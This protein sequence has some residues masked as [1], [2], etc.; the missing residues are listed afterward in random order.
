MPPK[1]SSG[2]EKDL[3]DE[4][5]VLQAVIL[6]DSFNKRFKPLTVGKPRC[7]LPVCNATLLDWTFESLALAGVQE[8]FVICRSYPELVKAAIRDSK[9]SKPM[10]GLKIV[11]IITSKETF[12]P[13]DAMRDIYTRGI[14][15]SDFVLVMG[16]LVSNVKIDEVVRVHK[17][18]RRTNK[19]AIMTMVVKESGSV[20]R[21]RSQG[22]SAVFVLDAETSECLHYESVIGYPAKKAVQIPREIFKDHP[23]L[24]VRYDLI[25]CCI[26]VCSVE[27]PSLFQDNFDYG[28]I[29]R[30]F[31]HGV[32]TSDLLMKSIHCYVLNEGYAARVADTRS[33]DAVS[34]DILSRWTFPLVPDDNHPGGHSYEHLRGNKYIAKGN[35]V[36]L[37]RTCKIGPNTLIGAGSTIS[38][39][40][41]IHASVIGRNCTISPNVVLKNVYVFDGTVIGE[42]SV[43]EETIIGENV[44]IGGGSRID[45]G[46]LIADGVVLGKNARLGPFDRVSKR[47]EVEKKKSINGTEESDGEEDEEEEDSELEDVEAHQDGVSV[48]IG[49]GSNA[50]V[51][52]Q[53]PREDDEDIDEVE[54]YS[55]QRLM[56]L[57]DTCSDLELEPEDDS[58]ANDSDSDDSDAE[59]TTSMGSNAYS[60]ASST[61]SYTNNPAVGIHNLQAA[62]AVTEFQYEVGQ[63]LERAFAEG[64]S[65]DNAAV[66]LKTLRMASNVELRKVRE[67]VVK[68]IVEKIRIVEEGG[69]EQR[70][71]IA[72][73][74]KRWGALIDKIGGVDAVETVEVLQYHCAQSSRLPLFGQI[75]AALYQED[76]VEEDDIR[77]WHRTAAAKGE[78]LK[79]GTTLLEHVQRCWT[80]GSKMIEQFDEQESS[81]EEESEEE[82]K[83]KTAQPTVKAKEESSEEEE[84]DDDDEESEE[85]ESEE[86][87]VPKAADVKP[88]P[89]ASKPAAPGPSVP[90]QVKKLAESSEEE[91][92]EDRDEEEE[93]E[94]ESDED[95][96]PTPPT[97]ANKSST[98]APSSSQPPAPPPQPAAPAP[99]IQPKKA[100]ETSE[101]EEDDDDEEEESGEEESDEEPAPA[102]KATAPAPAPATSAPVQAP[103]P[104][105][106]VAPASEEEESEEDDEDDEE[107]DSGEEE[108]E[109]EPVVAPAP[110][111]PATRVA[112]PPAAQQP[113]PP[114]PAPSSTSKP[115]ESSEEE[116]SEEDD[117]EEESEE[118]EETPAPSKPVIAAAPTATTSQQQPPPP[119]PPAAPSA[120]TPAASSSAPPPKKDETSEEESGEDDED[121]DEDDDDDEEEES[122]EEQEEEPTQK[123][124][125]T[126]AKFTPAEPAAPASPIGGPPAEAKSIFG[127]STPPP[128][129][130]S[131]ESSEEESGSEEGSEED[132]EEEDDTPGKEKTEPATTPASAPKPEEDDDPVVLKTPLGTVA[133][134]ESEDGSASDEEEDAVV[135]PKPAGAS[136]SRET[137]TAPPPGSKQGG[138][139]IV[140]STGSGSSEVYTTSEDESEEDDDDGDSRVPTT[141]STSVSTLSAP[142]PPH[143]PTA[144]DTASLLHG[145]ATAQRSVGSS[146]GSSILAPSSASASASASVSTHDD[147]DGNKTASTNANTQPLSPTPTPSTPSTPSRWRRG[148]KTDAAPGSSSGKSRSPSPSPPVPAARPRPRKPSQDQNQNQAN[149]TSQNRLSALFLQGPFQLGSS[150]RDKSPVSAGEKSSGDESATTKRG[151]RVKAKEAVGKLV[152]RVVSLT[153][154]PRRPRTPQPQPQHLDVGGTGPNG[155]GS[156]DKSNHADL[157]RRLVQRTHRAVIVP[158]YRLTRSD[159]PPPLLQH[160]H[161]AHAHDVLTFLH[162]LLTWPGPS[163][164]DA[165]FDASNVYL[166]GHSC[167]AHMLASIFL[168]SPSFGRVLQPSPAL[169]RATKGFVFSEG[170][171]DLDLLCQNFSDYK[172]WFVANAFGDKPSYEECNV[173]SYTLRE[174]GEHAKWLIVHNKGDA[175]V[176]VAQSEVFHGHLATLLEGKE[177]TAVLD[178]EAVYVENG[179]NE[180]LL[181]SAY[182]DLVGKFIGN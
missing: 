51:W 92:E 149:R 10:Y 161:P 123:V 151:K 21:T 119:P 62:A 156:E 65:V 32:L 147:S 129:R 80:V 66:E 145:V 29:R 105:K 175:L 16:D 159:D 9:W 79:E 97:T 50:V 180:V 136:T 154:L 99:A 85:E 122:E 70:K 103:V 121:D 37:S 3:T 108:S 47:R 134:S 30:D 38:D 81:E 2:K 43:I 163:G 148:K 57:G 104:P 52:P 177:G 7:L 113:A 26:D 27:V 58:T 117:D 100:E 96:K 48:I 114:A 78:H 68:A 135:V 24:E 12:T 95:D 137:I 116:E 106:P 42:G 41:S 91:S 107:E 11:P 127:A 132:E 166:I 112:T 39:N 67:A 143:A 178:M 54:R 46:C 158:N 31:V 89:P 17:E 59:S 94:D 56:R 8:I 77:A 125:A 53:G 34:K 76:I 157:A 33:Y 141:T 13:G 155:H 64:H 35:S 126:E 18:R 74:M 139:S 83:G 128:Q 118:E 164:D 63:S 142:H 173:A 1:S 5:D 167:S 90:A 182:I 140:V 181:Q 69:A 109:D 75:L 160:Q 86:E 88:Q 20:H 25:D 144:K 170:I 45:R 150:S 133:E 124:A 22:E 82:V 36:S 98:P 169:L 44:R 71:E 168:D 110:A 60:I 162:F 176:D 172:A 171:Y 55:N 14:I 179:H 87:A 72:G 49:E 61:T 93:E 153:S 138:A 130:G 146:R 120:P 152:K 19:D 23:E 111:T 102:P 101:E 73:V 115:E 6:A 15:T 165:P 131:T 28:D 4:D 40:A 84:E 174:G